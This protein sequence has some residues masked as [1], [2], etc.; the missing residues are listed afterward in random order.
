MFG[1]L[2]PRNHD[3]AVEIDEKNGNTKWQDAEKLELSQLAEYNTFE[4]K[5]KG[6]RVP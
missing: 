5:G 2:V 4:D 1:F 6:G 3:Q